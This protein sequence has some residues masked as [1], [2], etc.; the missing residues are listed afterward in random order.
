MDALLYIFIMYSM[1]F[2]S[3]AGQSSS[4]LSSVL[5]ALKMEGSKASVR[6]N[7]FTIFGD[8]WRCALAH[9]DVMEMW[10]LIEM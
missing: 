5:T 9:S 8:S 1:T 10:W 7:H 2:T 6:V 3:L 4:D